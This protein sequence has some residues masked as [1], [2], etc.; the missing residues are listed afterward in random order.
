MVVET[1]AVGGEGQVV[2]RVGCDEGGQ[3]HPSLS[4]GEALTPSRPHVEDGGGRDVGL[5]V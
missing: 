3:V 5:Q 1:L 4:L 2:P